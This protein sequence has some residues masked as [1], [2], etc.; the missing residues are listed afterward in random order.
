MPAARIAF[1]GL[2]AAP[3]RS[4]GTGGRG[5]RSAPEA[6]FE[7]ARGE[8][9]AGPGELEAFEGE[10]DVMLA[11]ERWR[12]V[13]EGRLKKGQSAVVTAIEGLILKIRPEKENERENDD[14]SDFR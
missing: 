14:G 11:G 3:T 8:L 1:L 2:I 13:V 6:V 12:A 4:G 7:S 5:A 10:G 9:E